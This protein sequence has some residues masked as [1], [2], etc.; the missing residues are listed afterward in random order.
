M[1][2][3]L[4]TPLGPMLARFDDAALTALQFCTDQEADA[5]QPARQPLERALSEQLQRYFDGA[6]AHFDL[7]LAPQG[8]PFSTAVW[9]ALQHIPYGQTAAYADIARAVGHPKAARAVGRAN[10]ANPICIIIPCHRVVRT[11]GAIG[12]YGGGIERKRVLLDIERR[13]M[14]AAT[15]A[16]L[17]STTAA[18]A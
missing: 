9:R 2:I 8:S 15:A 18:A 13:A 7:P 3:R 5:G 12:G 17:P 16:P 4:D 11:G 6:L 1:A 10:G 14:A